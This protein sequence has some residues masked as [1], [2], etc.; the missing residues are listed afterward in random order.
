MQARITGYVRGVGSAHT[1][2]GTSIWTDEPIAAASWNIPMG[3]Y[4]EV[5][6][7]GMYRVADRGMLGSSGW[8]DIAVYSHA[9][10]LAL[11]EVRTVCVL[12]DP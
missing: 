11:T 3:S 8:V 6:G 4:V 12:T 10:A 9:E 2:D 5:E 7:V 1:Y